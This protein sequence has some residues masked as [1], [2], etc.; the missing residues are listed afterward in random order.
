MIRAKITF[1][2]PLF[3][4]GAYEDLPEIRPASI[5]GQ[6][7][8]W[9]RILGGTAADEREIFGSVHKDFGG[10]DLKPAAS[11]L[12]V[13]AADLPSPD[14]ASQWFPTLPHKSG[15]HN[16][17]NAPNA[18]RGALP[19]GTS[20]TL[21][22][23]ERLGHLPQR[24]QGLIDRTIR[25]WL[26]MGAL[27]LRATRGG[28]SLQWDEAPTNVAVFRES[29]SVLLK[30][31]HIRFDILNKE[32][33]SAEDARK[34]ITETIAHP[35]LSDVSYPLGAVRQGKDDPAPSRKTSPLRLTIRRFDDGHRILAAW[36][37]RQSVT[38]NTRDHLRV[39]IDRLANG[40]TLSKPTEI[41]RL[42]KASCLS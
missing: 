39:A 22:V 29:L 27:G 24:Q 31:A 30:G 2:T 6:L 3:S 5:R 8:H 42:L 38:G 33:H 40:T 16:P 34:V 12:I 1:I 26:M 37:E 35:A 11:R 28:G 17:R 36:D 10:R 13:R 25:V 4:R 23:T 21:I 19:A 14:V 20:F 9:L 18:P 15:G 32:F 7:H 41:G